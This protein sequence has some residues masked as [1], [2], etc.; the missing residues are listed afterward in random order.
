MTLA[1]SLLKPPLGPVVQALPGS[2]A[3][4]NT[5]PS[6]FLISSPHFTFAQLL[7]V[8]DGCYTDSQAEISVKSLGV[9]FKSSGD[10][11]GV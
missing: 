5:P 10:I 9:S 2:F 11:E 8:R 3:G 7:L 6:P 4:L 1:T